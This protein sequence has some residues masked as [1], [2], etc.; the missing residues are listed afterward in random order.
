MKQRYDLPSYGVK[1]SLELLPRKD[2][3]ESKTYI[4]KTSS[5]IV[6]TGKT[7]DGES[8]LD[9]SGGPMIVVGKPLKE[10]DN[11]IVRSIDRSEGFGFTVTFR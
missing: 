6:R 1:N 3:S 2:G 10:A 9:L 7:N 5:D 4:V 11:A 8:F